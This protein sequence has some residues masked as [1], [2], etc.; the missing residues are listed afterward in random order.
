MVWVWPQ[1]A[2]AGT[3]IVSKADVTNYYKFGEI[4]FPTV[5]EARNP[6]S[7]CQQGLAPAE[8]ARADGSLPILV[9]S[10]W[11][12]LFLDLWQCNFN[13]WLHLHMAFSVHP[14]AFF[15]ASSD[16]GSTLTRYDLTS[17]LTLITSTKTVFPS[18]FIL[19][20]SK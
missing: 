20:G 19:W 14:C 18:K 13:L 16:L 9:S 1:A 3:L 6:K 4:Y 8:G 2:F 10:G 15:S 7:R 11:W 17:I 12:P 5:L